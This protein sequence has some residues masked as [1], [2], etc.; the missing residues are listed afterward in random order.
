MIYKI[1]IPNYSI[2]ITLNKDVNII[3]IIITEF[4]FSRFKQ[5]LILPSKSIGEFQ[6]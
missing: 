3:L 5:G 4:C 6:S 1:K 2:F